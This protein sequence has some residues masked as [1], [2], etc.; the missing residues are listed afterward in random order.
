MWRQPS[1]H[2]NQFATTEK[3]TLLCGGDVFLRNWHSAILFAES[4]NTCQQETGRPI[5]ELDPRWAVEYICPWQLREGKSWPESHS[6]LFLWSPRTRLSL[7]FCLFS[8]R[9]EELESST[10]T[11]QRGTTLL[12]PSSYF[13]WHWQGAWGACSPLGSILPAFPMF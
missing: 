13:S 9:S 12:N 8:K 1:W 2:A 7:A 6:D 10:M 3:Q 4:N 5:L 11:L